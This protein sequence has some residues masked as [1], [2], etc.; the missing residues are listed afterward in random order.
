MLWFVVNVTNILDKKQAV[1]QNVS[2]LTNIKLSAPSRKLKR[3]QNTTIC[4]SMTDLV[5]YAVVNFDALLL[6]T[7]FVSCVAFISTIL[8]IELRESLD[9]VVRLK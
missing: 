9:M 8:G 2:R 5:I 4:S 1:E 3:C 6:G 7:E